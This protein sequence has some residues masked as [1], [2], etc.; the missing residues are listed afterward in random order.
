MSND[1]GNVDPQGRPQFT[2]PP[3]RKFV[4]TRITADG[5]EEKVTVLAHSVDVAEQWLIFGV[6]ELMGGNP[7]QKSK[8]GIN[9]AIEYEEDDSYVDSRVVR[10]IIH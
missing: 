3:L 4:V 5:V 6:I 10:S 2:L 7:V 1:N 8:R 9:H